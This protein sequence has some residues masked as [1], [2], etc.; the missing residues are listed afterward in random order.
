MASVKVAVRVRPFNERELAHDSK[1]V[2]K[3]EANKTIIYNQK[4]TSSSLSFSMMHHSATNLSTENG[5]ADSDLSVTSREKFKE[6]VY[7]SSY[8]SFNP[9]D[10]HFVSQSDV[11]NDL[12]RTTVN[13]AFDGYNSCICAYGQT[14]SGKSYSMMGQTNCLKEEGLIPRIC[15]VGIEI[16]NKCCVAKAKNGR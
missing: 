14:G 9:D 13:N 7:D 2:I 8:W 12:G 15:K 16:W 11:Y 6:F 10:A 1:C 5:S 4:E 3:M